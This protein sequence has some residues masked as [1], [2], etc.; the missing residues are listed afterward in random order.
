MKKTPL[1]EYFQ[2]QDNKNADKEV[3]QA[4]KK[5]EYQRAFKG[6]DRWA[7][8]FL[9]RKLSMN[10]II[11][12]KKKHKNSDSIKSMFTIPFGGQ[13]EIQNVIINSLK[14]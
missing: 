8:T 7:P 14:K 9:F 5:T 3:I 1:F 12:D 6:A 10:V 4:S 13:V 2:I 11:K